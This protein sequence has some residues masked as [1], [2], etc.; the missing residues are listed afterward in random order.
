M[1]ILRGTRSA[2][3]FNLEPRILG[4]ARHGRMEPIE[5]GGRLNLEN[6][7][8]RMLIQINMSPGRRDPVSQINAEALALLDGS[9]IRVH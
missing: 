8:L 3:C 5:G 9:R 2:H 7:S 4:Q 1:F 6:G